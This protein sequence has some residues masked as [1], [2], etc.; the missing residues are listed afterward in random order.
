MQVLYRALADL[1]RRRIMDELARA[2]GLS[3]FEIHSRL[4][5]EHGTTSTRQAISQH[6]AVLEQAGLVWSER[7]G[8]TKVHH[9]DTAPLR[10]I[11]ERWPLS[12]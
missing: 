10:S 2:D 6:L 4:F 7:V 1:T 9:L 3:L 5:V 11:I 12:E 8:R